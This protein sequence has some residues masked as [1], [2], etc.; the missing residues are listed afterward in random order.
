MRCRFFLSMFLFLLLMFIVMIGLG[1]ELG[2]SILEVVMRFSVM[3]LLLW[4]IVFFSR[5]VI[6]WSSWFGFV[7]IL[8]RCGATC[9]MNLCLLLL[10]VIIWFMC[11]WVVI[12][13]LIGWVCIFR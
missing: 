2:V 10:L 7:Y 12:L 1:L 8:G 6:I 9:M 3:V 11:C 5:L 13:R 4:R